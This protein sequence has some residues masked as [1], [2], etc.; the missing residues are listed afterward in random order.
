MTNIDTTNQQLLANTNRVASDYAQRI[1]KI[2]N[3][4]SNEN[5]YPDVVKELGDIAGKLRAFGKTDDPQLDQGRTVSN[6]AMLPPYQRNTQGP[7]LGPPAAVAHLDR[8][9][10]Y[11]HQNSVTTYADGTKATDAA[12]GNGKPGPQNNSGFTK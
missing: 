6:R 9:I 11:D 12:V 8:G 5:S 1:D 2:C 7:L 4:M 10:R 3:R